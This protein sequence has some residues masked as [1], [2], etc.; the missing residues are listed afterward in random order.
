MSG[1]PVSASVSVLIPAY[2]AA[3]TL[4]P[5]VRSVLDQELEVPFEVIVVASAD[6]ADDLPRLAA[7]DQLRV[8]G[9]V[10]RLAAATARNR[11][12][13]LASGDVLVFLDA[14]VVAPPGWLA[15]LV[16]ASRSAG[17]TDVVAGAVANGTPGSVVGTAEYLVQ[18]SELAPALAPADHGATCNLLV[19]R[20]RWDELGPFPEDM[21]GGE[22]T[23][24]TI[25][26][27]RHGRFRFE[28]AAAVVH[29][30]RTALREVLAHQRAFGRF[31]A[32]LADRCPDLPHRRLLRTPVLVPVATAGRIVAVGRRAARLRR[33][34]PL[35]PR[36]I[37]VAVAALLAWGFG[38]LEVTWG[39]RRSPRRR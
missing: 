24:L 9:V 18:F 8:E 35:D 5:C 16:G 11:A 15:A 4:A 27:R 17:G 29:L 23:L 20:A 34:T 37:P 39:S 2:R 14:D 26:A 36:C 6:L 38:L 22:D 12:A 1:M 33:S 31:T 32:H 7:H 30:N 10:P 19:P 13:A 3:R 28:P 21:G 25:S